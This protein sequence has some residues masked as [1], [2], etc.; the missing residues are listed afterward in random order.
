MSYLAQIALFAGLALPGIA[1]AA[2]S[3]SDAPPEPTQTSIE[4]KKTEVWD[5]KTQKCVDAQSGQLDNDTLYQAAREL[6]F[7]LKVDP[8]T[9]FTPLRD[10]LADVARAM[11]AGDLSVT[12]AISAI[13]NS[14]SQTSVSSNALFRS[15]VS[16]CE[17]SL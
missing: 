2:G 9:D 10:G 17:T 1:F 14:S 13:P 15:S 8:Y 11:A 16:A 3:G 4:C 12:A 6:A 7:E 5:Q